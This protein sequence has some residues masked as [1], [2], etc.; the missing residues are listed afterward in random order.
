MIQRCLL[1]FGL[2]TSDFGLWLAN[3]CR[4]LALLLALL[5]IPLAA[6][7]DPAAFRFAWLSDTHVGTSTGEDDLRA[8]V[9]DINGQT[10]LSFVMVSGDVTETARSNNCGWPRNSSTG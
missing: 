4:R 7:A 5:S 9:K 6:L 3:R 1:A 8:A 10:G 2:R